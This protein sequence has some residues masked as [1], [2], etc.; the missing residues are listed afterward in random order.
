MTN[1]IPQQDL[2]DK[3]LNSS[4][5]LFKKKLASSPDEFSYDVD[6]HDRFFRLETP[7]FRCDIH[8]YEERKP[9][10]TIFF[11]LFYNIDPGFGFG[12]LVIHN[13]FGKTRFYIDN[14]DY[15]RVDD[16][17]EEKLNNCFSVIYKV[18]SELE[19]TS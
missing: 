15:G 13:G 4:R 7:E 18:L 12:I 1:V 3:I 9:Y 8:K 2:L 10:Y 16:Y 19:L 17:D 5:N 6:H 14:Y 11:D